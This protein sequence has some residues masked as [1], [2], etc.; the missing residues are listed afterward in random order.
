MGRRYLVASDVHLSRGNVLD[1]TTDPN[2][3]LEFLKYADDTGARVVLAG[4]IID[5]RG[6]SPAQIFR[7]H[8]KIFRQIT[9]MK[10]AGRLKYTAGNHDYRMRW[11]WNLP[12]RVVLREHNIAIIHGHQLDII[13]IPLFYWIADFA[14]PLLREIADRVGWQMEHGWDGMKGL[15]DK[16]AGTNNDGER[17]FDLG[18]QARAYSQMHNFSGVIY[19]HTH[20]GG[21]TRGNAVNSGCNVNGAADYVEV[22][23]R[24]NMQRRSMLHGF[25]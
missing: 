7:Y 8:R 17:Y 10:E 12:D 6:A 23:P 22:D 18:R 25:H 3:F 11:K 14:D 24:G 13:D 15:L 19:G 20:R 9:K 5:H 4:D 21:P 1:R 2:L 16:I